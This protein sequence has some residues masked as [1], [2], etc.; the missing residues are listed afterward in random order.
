[1]EHSKCIKRDSFIYQQALNPKGRNFQ[2]SMAT[3]LERVRMF[4]VSTA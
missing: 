3:R 1:M 4:G 2:A